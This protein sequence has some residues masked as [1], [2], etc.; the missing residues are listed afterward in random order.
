MTDVRWYFDLPRLRGAGDGRGALL[1]CLRRTYPGGARARWGAHLRHLRRSDRPRRAF[2]R[3]L[4]CSGRCCSLGPASGATSTSASGLSANPGHRG[5]AGSAR[6]GARQEEPELPHRCD[7]CGGAGAVARLLPGSRMGGAQLV[8][9]ARYHQAP[10]GHVGADVGAGRIGR[11]R[12]QVPLHLLQTGVTEV[13]PFLI[14]RPRR[15][16]GAG[17]RRPLPLYLEFTFNRGHW[18]CRPTE[19]MK[20]AQNRGVVGLAPGR[21]HRH[22][23]P[24][25]ADLHRDMRE[26]A[27]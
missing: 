26:L 12:R 15:A 18:C 19:I 17:G 13:A 16:R 25:A 8:G 1:W 14:L 9:R 2:L 11:A 27:R 23:A 20:G 10:T 22:M 3:F 24:A 7:R 4:R 21:R 5:G 6:G